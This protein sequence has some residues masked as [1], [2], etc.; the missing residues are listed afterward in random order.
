MTVVVIARTTKIESKVTTEVNSI[1]FR[2]DSLVPSR[3]LRHAVGNQ[4]KCELRVFPANR[5]E[6]TSRVGDASQRA[7]NRRARAPGCRRT[8]KRRTPAAC[9]CELEELRRPRA[10]ARA[11][12]PSPERRITR[13]ARACR[14]SP[15][16]RGT[17]RLEHQCRHGDAGTPCLHRA[18]LT[19]VRVARRSMR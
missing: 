9:P 11:P 4:S 14:A 15:S 8:P 6:S 10:R 5:A 16:R 17:R 2:L 1:C 18:A 19:R 12:A 7:V 3:A 13:A